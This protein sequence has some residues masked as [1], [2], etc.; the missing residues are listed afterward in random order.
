MGDFLKIKDEKISHSTSGITLRTPL[1]THSPVKLLKKNQSQNCLIAYTKWRK[2]YSHK[3]LLKLSKV[4]KGPWYLKHNP[5]LPSHLPAQK[6][7][8]T[9]RQV[10][11]QWVGCNFPHVPDGGLSFQTTTIS[12]FHSAST[13]LLLWTSSGWM[14]VRGWGFFLMPNPQ[15]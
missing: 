14:Q 2:M 3:K 11:L 4:R 12:I 10:C 13:S 5:Y 8:N 9:S 1:W 7:G 15:F 6:D